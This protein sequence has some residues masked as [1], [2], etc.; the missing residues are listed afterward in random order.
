MTTQNS[1]KQP[2]GKIANQLIELIV[3]EC[4]L[5][6]NQQKEPYVIMKKNGLR[7]VYSIGSKSFS[8]LVAS[9]YFASK[10]LRCQKRHLNLHSVRFQAKLCTKANALKFSLGLPKLKT[11]IGWICATKNGKLY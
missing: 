9:K 10:N 1:K 3:K 7:Q 6:H 5:V 11:A 4:E 2:E 8:D